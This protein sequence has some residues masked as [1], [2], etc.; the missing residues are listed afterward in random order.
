MSE[1]QTKQIRWARLLTVGVILL[2][3]PV[4]I[5]LSI[6]YGLLPLERY[7]L[8]W[9]IAIHYNFTG[10]FVAGAIV[11]SETVTH[12][13]KREADYIHTVRRMKIM[14]EAQAT[15]KRDYNKL[16]EQHGL[17]PLVLPGELEDATR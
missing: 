4:V 3:I 16:R 6:A 15:I 11:G 8:I 12:F 14:E 5:G 7:W 17:E 10:L 1:K 2:N 13:V 9:L